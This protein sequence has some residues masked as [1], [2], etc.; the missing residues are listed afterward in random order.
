M[1]CDYYCTATIRIFHF[2][3]LK[4]Y[5]PIYVEAKEM[6]CYVKEHAIITTIPRAIELNVMVFGNQM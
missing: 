5:F 4:Y 1:R 2:V 6:V 3:K